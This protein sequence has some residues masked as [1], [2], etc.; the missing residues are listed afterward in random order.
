MKPDISFLV[1]LKP[2]QIVKWF[3]SKDNRI[4]WDW[5]DTWQEA[6]AKS[7]TAAKAMKLDILNDIRKSTQKAIENGT[8]FNQ[9]K[10]ELEPTLKRSGWWGKVKAKDVPGY[11]PDIK[12][13]P[14]KVVQLG[15]PHRLKTIYSTNLSVAYSAGRYKAMKENAGDRPYWMYDA[16]MD[17]NTRL[18]HAKLHGK[19][20]RHDDPFWDVYLPP[21]D[22]G[23]RCGVIPITE[24]E[25]EKDNLKIEKGED[26]NDF[27]PGEGWAHNPGKA[28]FFPD[29]NKY[30]YDIASKFVEHGLDNPD[31]NLFYE[32]KIKGN[33]PVAVIDKNYQKLIAAK[34]NNVL[35]SDESLIKNKKEQTDLTIKDYQNIPTFISKAQLIVKDKD[36]VLVFIKRNGKIFHSVIKSTGTGDELFLTS[37]RITSLKD[38]NRMR[39][40]G[41]IVKDEF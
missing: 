2:E 35:L 25:V 6:H 23:C 29:L 22:W 10:R 15:S 40:R 14:D 28:A 34:T 33:F 8:T 19:V 3:N 21:N 30:D 13:D 39:K 5:R 16:T 11:S 1:N 27:I 20:Y 26:F 31:F 36:N 41:E 12:I 4:S 38:V 24:K 18:G 7:F 17:S 37:L 9:F 32:G